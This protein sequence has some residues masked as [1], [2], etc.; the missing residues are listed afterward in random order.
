MG[1]VFEVQ[2]L[3]VELSPERKSD[4]KSFQKNTNILS[5]QSLPKNNKHLFIQVPTPQP[6]LSFSFVP[7]FFSF[8]QLLLGFAHLDLTIW[9]NLGGEEAPKGVQPEILMTQSGLS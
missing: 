9:K 7:L 6:Q 5:L 3:K 4:L 1:R 8:V 2:I